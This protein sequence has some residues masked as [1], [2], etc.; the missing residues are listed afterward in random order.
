[1][2][3]FHENIID[4]NSL[5]YEDWYKIFMVKNDKLHP[6]SCFPSDVFR[7]RYISEVQTKSES[8]VKMLL[9]RIIVKSSNFGSDDF[10]LSTIPK[11]DVEYLKKLYN[12]SEYHRRLLSKTPTHEGITWVLDM[13]PHWPKKAIDALSS[14]FMCNWQMLPDNSVS[15]LGDA[16]EVISAR[17]VEYK[18]EREILLDLDPLD[19]EL[20]V[21]HLYEQMDF[22]VSETKKSHD[23]GVDLVAR[24]EVKNQGSELV[25][26]QCKRYKNKI[27]VGNMREF[28]GAAYNYVSLN[29]NRQTQSVMITASSF[30]K[31]AIKEF[32]NDHSMK[33][34]DHENLIKLL[35]S[36]C[37]TTWPTKLY[38]ILL[39]GK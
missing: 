33:M 39:K 24:K 26:I 28:N 37:G 14:Y 12:S 10:Y 13:L 16:L 6:N 5:S 32:K 31:S 29:R 4:A 34:I 36:Y 22:S 15:G 30:T 20:L 38:R 23:G 35:N 7:D 27:T 3:Y 17:F 18:H 11:D 9:R 1:M 21:K 25:L 19:F 8:E 2:E